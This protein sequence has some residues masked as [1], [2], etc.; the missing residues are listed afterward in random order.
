MELVHRDASIS[1]HLHPVE[2]SPGSSLEI[3][4]GNPEKGLAKAGALNMF[5]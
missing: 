1:I 5:Q 4:H 3:S 2:V